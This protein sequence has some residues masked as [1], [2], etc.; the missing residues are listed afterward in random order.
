MLTLWRGQLDRGLVEA[1][2][3]EIE[4][5]IRFHDEELA[6]IAATA[7]LESALLHLVAVRVLAGFEDDQIYDQLHNLVLSLDGPRHPL[8]GATAR[9]GGDPS[10]RRGQ[11]RTPQAG[12]CP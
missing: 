5:W 6:E 9:P 2:M 1:D 3:S 10:S 11:P 7:D 12:G 8:A 4:E